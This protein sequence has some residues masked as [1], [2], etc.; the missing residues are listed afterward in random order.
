MQKH[1]ASDQAQRRRIDMIILAQKYIDRFWGS[2]DKEK[3]T[4]FYNGTRCW[5]W[6]SVHHQ[7][8]GYGTI[9][10]GDKRRYAHRISWML[11]FGE[12]PDGLDVCHSCDNTPCV[13]PNHLFLGTH[14]ENMRDRDRKG[15]RTPLRGQENGMSKLTNEQVEE[16]RRRYGRRNVGGE[17]SPKLAKEFGVSA[18]SIQRIVTHKQRI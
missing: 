5:E 15:R 17:S 16:I 10:C 2:I 13:N 1:R 6:T 8:Q 11:H 3:S 7:T 12:I 4:I 14:L 9:W 18:V